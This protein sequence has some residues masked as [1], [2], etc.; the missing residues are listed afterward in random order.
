[1]GRT[2]K[3][4]K[5]RAIAQVRNHDVP[6]P[7]R[8]PK[9]AF[10][11]IPKTAGTSF[12]AALQTAW[13]RARIVATQAEFDA[14]SDEELA[15]LDLIAGHY[16]GHRLEDR[17]P[18][19]FSA[20]TVLRDPFE[21]LFSA[22]RFG[23]QFARSGATVGPA[24]RLAGEVDF[25]TW[26]FAPLAANQAHAQLYQ[27][28]LNRGD[29]AGQMTLDRLLDQA[30]ARLEGMEVAT[31][32]RLDDFVKRLFR[33]HGKGEPPLVE[34]AMTTRE[35]YSPEEAG[36]TAAQRAALMDRL[37][38]DFALHDHAR[39]VMLRRFEAG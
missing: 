16:F 12:T 33:L 9:L 35:R 5:Q 4:R 32:D 36:L 11:H 30:K 27:L 19:R 13:P 26:A 25:G 34:R 14:V 8:P 17:A 23:R 6:Q 29:R 3:R 1:L 18:G 37:Q 21:R 20:V 22:Y 7:D 2:R 28:G 15:S 38:P 10:V 24:M 31:T 39:A